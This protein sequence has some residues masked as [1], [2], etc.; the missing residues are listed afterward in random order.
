MP[1]QQQQFIRLYQ[2]EAG[3]LDARVSIR[4]IGGYD[5]YSV[6]V[7]YDLE[8]IRTTLNTVFRAAVDLAIYVR[9]EHP[10]VGVHVSRQT[11][12]NVLKSWE[13]QE[14]QRQAIR[15][16]QRAMGEPVN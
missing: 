15:F 1:R 11:L 13:R 14:I 3:T 12:R 9:T 5:T 6:V 7:P 2:H 10:D 4:V 16:E 8:N